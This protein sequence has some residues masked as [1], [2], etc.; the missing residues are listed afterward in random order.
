MKSVLKPSLV[1]L[2]AVGFASSKI[3]ANQKEKDCSTIK[4]SGEVKKGQAFEKDVNAELLFKLAP[5]LH[6]ANPQGWTIEIRSK[7]NP[8][9]DYVWVA[10]PPY[11]FSNPRTLDTAYGM[12]ARQA[13]DWSPRTFAFVLN[14]EDYEKLNGAVRTLLWPYTYTEKERD[15]AEKVWNELV[16]NHAGQGR[17]E[18]VDFRLGSA[19]REDEVGWIESLKFDVELCLPKDAPSAQTGK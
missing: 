13:V 10:T 2:L 16:E 15:Q 1:L 17:L 8:E 6:P 4:F 12:S 7:E 11:R 19:G 3:C 5:E 14:Q 18:I 9:H